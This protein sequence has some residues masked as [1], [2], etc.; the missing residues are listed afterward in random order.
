MSNRQYEVNFVADLK[1]KTMKK[2]IL[3][4]TIA[5]TVSLSASAKTI[6]KNDDDSKSI[7]YIVMNQFDAEF[8]G[9]K[10]VTW[11]LTPTSQKAEFVLN[12]VKQTAFYSL[13]G[14]F[15]GVT[16]EVSYSVIPDAAQKD[17]AADYQGYTVGQVIKFESSDDTSSSFYRAM[18]MEGPESVAYFVDLKKDDGQEVLVRVNQR[19]SVFFFKQIK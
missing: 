4:A 7:S 18:A 8:S 17:I 19:G 15:L 14:T 6:V 5:A 9:A 11:T 12:G 10:N 2:L 3:A 13:T 1:F 16:Q